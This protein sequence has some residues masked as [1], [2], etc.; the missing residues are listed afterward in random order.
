MVLVQLAEDSGLNWDELAVALSPRTKC[1]LIQRSCGYSWR[2]SLSVKE[3]GKAIKMI[4]AS[5]LEKPFFFCHYVINHNMCLNTS[6]IDILHL[7]CLTIDGL[8]LIIQSI[9]SIHCHP[10]FCSL[11]VHWIPQYLS[12]KGLPFWL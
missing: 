1:A 11:F 5:S 7:P 8:Q 4:K 6:E 12:Y 9:T 2:R 3:I 10:P